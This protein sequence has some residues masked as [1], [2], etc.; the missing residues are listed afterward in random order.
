MKQVSDTRLWTESISLQKNKSIPKEELYNLF[1]MYTMNIKKEY[2]LGWLAFWLLVLDQLTKYLFFDKA[3]LADW[4][5]F[6]PAFNT[7]VSWS[8]QI[9]IVIVILIA[10]L[11]LWAFVVAYQRKYFNWLVL[12]LLL[13]GTLWNLLD[14]VVLQWVRDFI[15]VWSRFYDKMN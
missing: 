7:G 2:K 12:A 4:P 3:Y 14:R 5:V 15:S 13:A 11:A 1:F 6:H 8:V 9:P 10:G